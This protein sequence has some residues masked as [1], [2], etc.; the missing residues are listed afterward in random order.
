MVFDNSSYRL[1][2]DIGKTESNQY[3]LTQHGPIFDFYFW[4]GSPEK[5]LQSYTALTGKPP[6]PPRWAFEPWMGR[7]ED[8]WASGPQ[9]DPIAEEESVA[10]RFAEL[11][12]PHSAIY[13]EGV[14]A[15][16]PALNQFMAETRDQGVGLFLSRDI[17]SL[18]SNGSCRN[19]SSL[20]FRYLRFA[21]GDIAPDPRH[22]Y[23]DF[24]HPN[25]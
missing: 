18:G 5:R 1:R 11:D 17:Q 3:R 7:G 6:L 19:W 16:S 15:L 12:I 8:A 24:T 23:I 21:N 4:I 10:K 14:T 25:A 20:N 2:A 9:H 13:A 22:A